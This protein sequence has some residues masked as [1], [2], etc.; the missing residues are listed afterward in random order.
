MPRVD[1]S[2]ELSDKES[3]SLLR[4]FYLETPKPMGALAGTFLAAVLIAA[5]SA[6]SGNIGLAVV[7]PSLWVVGVFVLLVVVPRLLPKAVRAGL[8]RHRTVSA[9]EHGL[10]VDIGSGPSVA[11][12]TDFRPVVHRGNLWVVPRRNGRGGVVV[13][14]RAFRSHEDEV[15]F[16]RLASGHTGS[17]GD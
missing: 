17:A 11:P 13:P 2:Y 15:T 7:L 10:S 1:V 8:R 6:A 9:T 4:R 5:A 14:E 12:W 3:R 16:G